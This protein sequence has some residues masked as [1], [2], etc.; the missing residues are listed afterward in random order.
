MLLIILFSFSSSLPSPTISDLTSHIRR[1]RMDMVGQR[2]PRRG[3]A[4]QGEGRDVEEENNLIR[5]IRVFS[6]LNLF[7]LNEDTI[8][9]HRP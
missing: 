7:P 5:G 9:A 6:Y 2:R 1:G 8:F 4:G 3:G